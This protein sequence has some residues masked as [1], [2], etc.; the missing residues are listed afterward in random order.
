MEDIK[1]AYNE[2]S[3]GQMNDAPEEEE[4]GNKFLKGGYKPSR[5]IK[6]YIANKEGASMKTNRSFEEEAQSFWSV[7]PKDVRS[8]L[9]QEQADALYSYSYNVGAGNFKHRVFLHSKDTSVAM[10]AWRMCKGTC[11]PPR[12]VSL[13]DL[14][15]GE[16][17]RGQCLQEA[18]LQC[19]M[20]LPMI[21]LLPA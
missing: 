4:E 6:N 1:N 18:R 3:Q 21:L 16:Q 5:N 15:T 13:E 9:T 19:I 20:T 8:K 14:P 7:L 17:R 11:M 12:T 2:L 10:E